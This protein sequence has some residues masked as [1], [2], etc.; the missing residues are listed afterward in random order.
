MY[1]KIKK[2]PFWGK[3]T[4]N[5]LVVNTNHRCFDGHI[6]AVKSLNHIQISLSKSKQ[7]APRL[8][9]ILLFSLLST[10]TYPAHHLPT[11]QG[12]RNLYI[13]DLFESVVPSQS[14]TVR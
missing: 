3:H 14:V 4:Q 2:V 6:A 8:R 5:V 10:L 13:V 1:K 7:R 12:C 9:S 11:C